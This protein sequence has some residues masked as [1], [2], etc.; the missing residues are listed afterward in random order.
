M[1]ELSHDE[2][3]Q[4]VDDLDR[5]I[6]RLFLLRAELAHV[7]EELRVAT[8]GFRLALAWE[9]QTARCYALA[10]GQHGHD[11]ALLVLRAGRRATAGQPARP[12]GQAA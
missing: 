3:R 4:R 11:L 9:C 5:E 1:N 8:G 7:T 2:M 12:S 6:I 10:L